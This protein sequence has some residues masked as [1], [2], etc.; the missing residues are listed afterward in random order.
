[1]ST[2]TF[3]WVFNVIWTLFGIGILHSHWDFHAKVA[4]DVKRFTGIN[5]P[6]ALDL[7]EMPLLPWGCLFIPR[8][9]NNGGEEV[10]N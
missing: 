7:P 6:L 9:V 5:V 4:S 8:S 1:M 2:Y 3:D 10:H